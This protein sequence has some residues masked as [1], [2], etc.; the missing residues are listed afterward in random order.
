MARGSINYD[1]QNIYFKKNAAI[2]RNALRPFPG[3]LDN[4]YPEDRNIFYKEFQRK[5]L[6]YPFESDTAEDFLFARGCPFQCS[7]C[8]NHI[9]KTL[10]TGKYITFPS[11]ETVIMDILHAKNFREFHK[12]SFHDDI[13]TLNKPWFREL[14]HAYSARIGLPFIC[15]LRIGTF[16]EEDVLLLKK[17]NCELAILGIESGNDAIR[18]EVLRKNLKHDNILDGFRLLHRYGIQTVSQNMVGIP[19]ED[20]EKFY[21]TVKVNARLLPNRPVISVYF[22]YP[23]TR[24]FNKA[25]HDGLIESGSGP[26]DGGSFVER[27]TSVLKLKGFPN[28]Q[29]NFCADNFL[30]MVLWEYVFARTVLGSRMRKL[31]YCN[32]FIYKSLLPLTRALLAV[33]RWLVRCVKALQ[34]RSG[35]PPGKILAPSR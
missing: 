17:A 16:N 34:N 1:I 14:M 24:L 33:R 31:F 13:L 35:K 19:G 27:K 7:F 4:Y 6:A 3:N 30:P 15:N 9:L 11:V 20:F 18:N 29:V 25:L 2:I 8:S 21:D 12:V 10:G 23:G 26:G 28:D 22:P 5:R 32:G